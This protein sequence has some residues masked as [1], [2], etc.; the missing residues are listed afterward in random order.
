M[1]KPRLVA[2]LKAGLGRRSHII[3]YRRPGGSSEANVA[4]PSVDNVCV[5]TNV[6][7]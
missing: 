4:K 5:A 3:I 6:D 7:R 2:K 1:P